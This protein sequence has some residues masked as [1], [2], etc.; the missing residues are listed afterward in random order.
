MNLALRIATLVL[1]STLAACGGQ[2]KLREGEDTG[3][4]PRIVPPQTSALP[5]VEIAPARGWDGVET[6]TPAAG[7]EV[8]A[9]ATGLN[10][11]RW[12]HV[13]PN[14]DVLVAESNAPPGKRGIKGLKGKV[15][16]AVMKRGET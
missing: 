4:N 16:A 9:L 5:V 1:A 8:K 12:L 6:P 11:P 14:G 10:H 3:A 15:M 2:A 7:L 13:L